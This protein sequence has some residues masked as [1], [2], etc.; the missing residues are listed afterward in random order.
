MRFPNEYYQMCQ[1]ISQHFPHLRLSQK[2][3]LSLWVYGCILAHSATQ[4]AVIAALWNVG[5]WNSLRQYLREWLYDGINK[6]RPN[7]YQVEVPACFLSLTK[8][9]LSL[10]RGDHLAM[11][12]D[13]TICTAINWPPWS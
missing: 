1:T 3:G 4:S 7:G 6:A 9:L 5:K 12:I 11:A 13:T 2:R 10:W 8:W